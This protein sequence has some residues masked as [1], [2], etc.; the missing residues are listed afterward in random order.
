MPV[1]SLRSP[2]LRW[3][4]RSLVR[5]AAERWARALLE[6]D[7][8]VIRAGY[9]GSYAT[10][11]DGVGSDLDLLVVLESSDEPFA[12]RALG[13]DTSGLPVPCDL[14]VYTRAEIEA[15]FARGGRFAEELQRRSVWFFRE[16]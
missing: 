16:P 4:E 7:P 2:V 15:I 10:G 14:F 1:R 9:F 8:T 11:R 5:E 6:R 12:R 3:P 13:F